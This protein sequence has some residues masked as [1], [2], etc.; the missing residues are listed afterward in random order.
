MMVHSYSENG[1]IIYVFSLLYV[2]G[3]DLKAD[4][5]VVEEATHPASELVEG[6]NGIV[7]HDV[8]G[9]ERPFTGFGTDVDVVD[10]FN[11]LRPLQMVAG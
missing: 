7:D 3:Y 5:M 6:I 11:H 2:I 4:W 10:H 8:N 9:E 1:P